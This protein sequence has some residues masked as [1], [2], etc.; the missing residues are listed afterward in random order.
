[1]FLVVYSK[2]HNMYSHG[3]GKISKLMARFL[4]EVEQNCG[5]Y[6]WRFEKSFLIS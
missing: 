1:M 5:I 6:C 2:V 3:R 4:H